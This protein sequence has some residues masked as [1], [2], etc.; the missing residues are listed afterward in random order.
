MPY[1]PLVLSDI[2]RTCNKIRAAI[3]RG[4]I[5]LWDYYSPLDPQ[6]NSLISESKFVSVLT[7]PLKGPVGL[8][9]QEIAELADYFR[10]HD[11]R[12]FYTQFCQV[13]HDSGE[14]Y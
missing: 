7:G 1:K 3:F 12:I 4:G 14:C 5:N 10:V 11:G 6:K 13:I 9:D 8:S 2:W